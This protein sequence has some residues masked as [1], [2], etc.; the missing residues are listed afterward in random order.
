MS[1]IDNIELLKGQHLKFTGV[2]M[3][4][5]DVN[6]WEKSEEKEI[7][8]IVKDGFLCESEEGIKYNLKDLILS[9]DI[10]GLEIIK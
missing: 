9:Y 10:Y 8:L 4:G 3:H 1:K 6:G 7:D 2:N 5:D